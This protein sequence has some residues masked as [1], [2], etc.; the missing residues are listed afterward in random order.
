MLLAGFVA[1]PP[2]SIWL[3]CSLCGGVVLACF[4]QLV[5][6]L[7]VGFGSHTGHDPLEEGPIGGRLSHAIASTSQ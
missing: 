6:L 1:L 4:V 2:E 7:H 5:Q 3:A